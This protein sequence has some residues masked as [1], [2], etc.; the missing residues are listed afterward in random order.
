[1][2]ETRCDT[3]WEGSADGFQRHQCQ[4]PEGHEDAHE[5]ACGTIS[6]RYTTE[7]WDPATAHQ[8]RVEAR[9]TDLL[10]EELIEASKRPASQS[11]ETFVD[12]RWVASKPVPASWEI[13]PRWLRRIVRRLLSVREAKE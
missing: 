12:G 5:C 10:V 3:W 13:W 6:Y 2:A 11:V 7:P 8:R 9:A 1:M 4:K